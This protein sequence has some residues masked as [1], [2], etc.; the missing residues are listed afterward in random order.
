[1]APRVT[2]V[3]F[4]RDL[5]L[6]DQPALH[7][8]CAGGGVVVPVFVWDP[9]GQ[10]PWAPGAASRWWLGQS[11]TALDTDLR[12]AGS[13]L[14]LRQGP[15]DRVLPELARETGATAVTYNRR[16]EPAARE[17]EVAV[18][19]ALRE[20]GVE[21]RGFD[22]GVLRPPE[23]IRTSTGGHYRV[24]TPFARACFA[25]GAVDGLC[26]A[27]ERVPAPGAW[28]A[29][30]ALPPALTRAVPGADLAAHW[31]PGAAA[32]RDR[33]AHFAAFGA[34]EYREERDRP[35]HDGTSRLSPHLH[36]GEVSPRRLWNEVS[37]RRVLCED[38]DEAEG[39]RTWLS[40]LLWREFSIHL[41][42]HEPHTH[43]A[44]LR[45]AFEAF[46]WR[47]DAAAFRA[48]HEGRTGYPYVDA[49]MRQLNETGWMHNRVRMAA[50]S[51]LVKH[52]LLP[53]QVGA[54][55]FWE[56]LVDADL[57]NNTMGWQWTA[58]CGADAAPYFRIFNPVT[59]GTRFDPHGD[60]VRRWVPELDQMPD[61]H[62][63]RPWE[64]S[65]G[66]RRAADVILGEDYPTPMVDHR[67]ARERALA[68]Y[69][70]IKG[71]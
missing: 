8:A 34:G 57:A 2:I 49:G 62:L 40:Q 58:G 3:W 70:R 60:Y 31:T 45:E 14:V 43:D 12:E 56:R 69:V 48:W 41:L 4:R 18:E 39:L 37:Y 66:G 36:F 52:L 25:R 38:P 5:R 46:P 71:R 55:Y 15:A 13:R 19:A 7:A 16:H 24:Y 67:A 47:D 20:A 51:F 17:Q 1:M 22:G 63:M 64:L 28:P 23:E 26:P 35:D 44:P 61:R 21:V 33:L 32:A 9:D 42:H 6:D 29:S 68:A 50:A 27:P 30:D 53:W 65:E 11:L 54:R 10:Q 59:Q